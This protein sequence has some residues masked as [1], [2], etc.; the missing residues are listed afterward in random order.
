M[1]RSDQFL[2][3]HAGSHV[4]WGRPELSFYSSEATQ[5]SSDSAR[6]RLKLHVESLEVDLQFV[7]ESSETETIR[8][9]ISSIWMS[10]HESVD[11]PEEPEHPERGT[12]KR[13]RTR[14]RV[15]N[16]KS[17]N[18]TD[19]STRQEQQEKLHALGKCNP[20]HYSF[21][22]GL[23]RKG[24]DCWFCHL[25]HANQ[26]R[27]RPRPSLRWRCKEEVNGLAALFEKDPQKF[28][29]AVREFGSRGEYMRVL[30][31]KKLASMGMGQELNLYD[32]L[33]GDNEEEKEYVMPKPGRSS[34]S[35]RIAAV[36]EY[37]RLIHL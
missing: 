36:T 14:T 6:E 23:C 28:R 12:T 10:E 9:G 32:Y 20:C 29:E 19:C 34:S 13:T 2:P 37:T 5:S 31:L 17:Q 35:P 15:E 11:Q 30:V 21:T 18:N 27:A 22:K 8:S 25:P 16:Q 1:W 26:P 3:V 33:R 4:I 7:Q 24:A